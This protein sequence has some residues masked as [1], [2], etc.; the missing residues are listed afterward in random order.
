MCIFIPIA[1]LDTNK[2]KSI[3]YMADRN[4]IELKEQSKKYVAEEDCW[5]S[6]YFR[7]HLYTVGDWTDWNAEK[8]LTTKIYLREGHKDYIFNVTMYEDN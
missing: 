7:N 2:D 4:M 6:E 1:I 8:Y 3:E 5:K